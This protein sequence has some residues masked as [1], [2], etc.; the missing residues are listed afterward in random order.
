M[1]VGCHIT[2]L[3]LL[4]FRETAAG[5][6][7]AH[8]EKQ[9]QQRIPHSLQSI[10][11][12]HDDI[13]DTAALEVFRRCGDELPDFCKFFV[14]GCQGRIDGVDDEVVDVGSPP[15]LHICIEIYA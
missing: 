2:F 8:Y 1:S 11:D 13:P 3:T 4:H 6:Y 5:F 14:P 10:V 7:N 9:Y 15:F 12:V